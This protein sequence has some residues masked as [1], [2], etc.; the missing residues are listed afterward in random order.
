MSHA[1][2]VAGSAGCPKCGAEAAARTS[3]SGLSIDVLHRVVGADLPALNAVILIELRVGIRLFPL[4]ARGLDIPSFI[5]GAA[6]QHDR[7]AVPLPGQAEAGE[8]F[9]QNRPRHL[10]IRPS[11]AGI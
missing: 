3:R 2:T 7:L 11:L 8:R 1:L 10:G 5:G 4:G 6:L 9:G